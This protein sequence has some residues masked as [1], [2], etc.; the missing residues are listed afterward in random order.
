MCID[1]KI[2]Y[3]V[4]LQVQ[5]RTFYVESHNTRNDILIEAV[6]KKKEKR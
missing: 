6:K 2:R 4:G 3:V 1:M 5:Q